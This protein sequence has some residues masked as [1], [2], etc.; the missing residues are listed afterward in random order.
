[1]IQ[2]VCHIRNALPHSALDG[3][4]PYEAYYKRK[5]DLTNIRVFGCAVYSK[6]TGK[7]KKLDDRSQLGTFIGFADGTRG[8]KILTSNNRITTS[9]DCIFVEA[10]SY[11]PKEDIENYIIETPWK[12]ITEPGNY[13]I[14]T[15]CT[16]EN[17]SRK[18]PPNDVSNDIGRMNSRDDNHR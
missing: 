16:Q 17:T 5:P 7:L 6:R 8:W 15:P 3:L 10:A 9:K 12:T 11:I 13:E 18:N 1:V 4:T 2:Y 14:T